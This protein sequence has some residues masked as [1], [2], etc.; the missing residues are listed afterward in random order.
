VIAS[1]LAMNKQVRFFRVPQ[2][3]AITGPADVVDLKKADAIT[4]EANE[5]TTAP[6][7]DG[8]SRIVFL[9]AGRRNTI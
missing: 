1:A 3:V 9:N 5:K 4:T 6:T 2:Q 8:L 7:K